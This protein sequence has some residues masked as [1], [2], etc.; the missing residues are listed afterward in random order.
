MVPT[1]KVR[2]VTGKDIEEFLYQQTPVWEESMKNVRETTWWGFTD[3]VFVGHPPYHEWILWYWKRAPRQ[4]DLKLLTNDSKIEEEMKRKKL[5]RRETRVMDDGANFTAGQWVLG[6]YIVSTVTSSKPHYLTQIH[7]PV[8]AH[9]LREL[10][11]NL[12][13]K[14]G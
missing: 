4:F 2:V 12:W 3:E 6:D 7:D 10:Y 8:L 1:P 11:K 5:T 14:Y 13:K 9:N